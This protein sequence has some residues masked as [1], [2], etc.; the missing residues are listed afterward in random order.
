MG[1]KFV[2]LLPN[3]LKNNVKFFFY[4]IKVIK[5]MSEQEKKNL[6]W[7]NTAPQ[8]KERLKWLLI[9][10]IIFW[11]LWGIMVLIF[12]DEQLALAANPGF[13]IDETHWSYKVI[14]IYSDSNFVLLLGTILG[15]LLIL[16]IPKCEPYR[17]PIL[18]A[19]ASVAIAGT[20]V[21]IIKPVVG[22]IRPFQ[23]GSPIADQ[24]NNFDEPAN[25]GSMPSG[26]VAATGSAALPHAIWTTKKILSVIIA[27]YS[28]G[29]MYVRMYL[30]VHYATD[31]LV[32]NMLAVMGVIIAFFVF[33]QI[34]KNGS[35]KRKYEWFIFL[36]ILLF[37]V[38]LQIIL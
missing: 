27:V 33:Q 31:V 1:K 30:G 37:M 8:A 21:G 16:I 12:G 6:K 17:R 34:Y 2:N 7:I 35:I 22:R 24:I 36:G 5:K 19:F 20:F 29:M 28:A 14:K 3:S 11:I 13:T 10:Q 15:C 25:L 38:I 18:E 32:S 26:H 9:G 4:N 23:E